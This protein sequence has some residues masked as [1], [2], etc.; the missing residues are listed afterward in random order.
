MKPMMKP[1]RARGSGKGKA[2][3]ILG[4]DAYQVGL[5]HI[6]DHLFL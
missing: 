1:K 5:N 6:R 2:P 3:T 4:F